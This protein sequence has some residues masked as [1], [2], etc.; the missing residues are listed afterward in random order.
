MT[1]PVTSRL[2]VRVQPNASRADIAGWYGGALRVRTTAPPVEGKANLA[3]AAI[4]ARALH[5]PR[6]DVTVVRG[7][8]N[9][10][11]VMEIIGIDE[12][13]VLRRLGALMKSDA[14]G[15]TSR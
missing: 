8:G 1:K 3:A 10:D 6:T 11:K 5:I 14:P 2:R 7:H 13:E 4:V 9:R 15:T 12:P